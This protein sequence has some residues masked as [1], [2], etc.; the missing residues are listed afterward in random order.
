MFFD[1]LIF[2]LEVAS[3][4]MRGPATVRMDLSSKG[5]VWKYEN[6]VPPNLMAYQYFAI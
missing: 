3:T 2:Q 5:F 6:K 1:I 4:D